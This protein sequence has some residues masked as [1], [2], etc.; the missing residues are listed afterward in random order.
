MKK[1]FFDFDGTLVNVWNRY[2]NILYDFVKIENPEIHFTISEYIEA[3]L[4]LQKDHLVLADLVKYDLNID[5]Y[6]TFKRKYLEQESYLR[7]DKPI[8]NFKEFC[9]QMREKGYMIFLV[10]ARHSE[11]MFY[12][13]L[14]WLG[15]DKLFDEIKIISPNKQ[16][17]LEYFK[18]IAHTNDVIVGDSMAEL[19]GAI[20]RCKGYFV[21]S[22][23]HL[24]DETGLLS[25]GLTVIDDYTKLREVL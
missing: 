10:S 14:G 13:Q 25:L 15:Y 22:G 11:N 17:K 18:S 8:G 3:K 19:E 1:I 7:L 12:K 4:R 6:M 5:K 20:G 21:R 24:Y 16:T 2:Y 23:L 9:I